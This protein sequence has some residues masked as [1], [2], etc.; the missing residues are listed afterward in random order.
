MSEGDMS[1]SFL[2]PGDLPFCA[3]CGHHSVAENTEKALQSLGLKPLDVVIV[4]DIGCHGIIDRHFLTHTVHGLHGRS[5]AL[6][7]GLAMELAGRKKVIVFIGDGGVTIGISHLIVAASK[8]IDMTVVVHNNFLYGMTGGQPSSLTPEG[9]K[10]SVAP[11]GRSERAF[12]ACRVLHDAGAAWVN[13]VVARNDYAADLAEAISH[14]GFALLEVLGLC[15]AYGV[16]CNPGMK[17]EDTAAKAGLALGKSL[18][19]DIRAYATPGRRKTASLFAALK[20]VGAAFQSQLTQPISIVLSGSAGEGVQL[21]AEIFVRAA[22][23]SGLHVTRKGNYPVTVGVGFSAAEIIVSPQPF[24]FHGI[25]IPD[26]ALIT[27]ADGLAYSR[28][29]LGM[30]GAGHIYIDDSLE[31]PASGAEQRREPFRKRAGKRYAALAALCRLL[32]REK[33]FPVEALIAE[34]KA[35]AIGSK[36]DLEKV[37]DVNTEA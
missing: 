1:Q 34:V 26:A 32:Q 7:A 31:A 33:I 10:T 36:V 8:N 12:D 16:K 19:P 23:A 22:M 18:T 2:S 37:L 14:K 15:T 28:A 20:P 17:L 27:S 25:A 30:M 5:V 13:R 21:A 24:R 6:G 9:F 29:Q 3:G 11:E 4:T 35:S